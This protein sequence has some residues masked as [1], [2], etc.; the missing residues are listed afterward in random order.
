MLVVPGTVA[1][2]V[3]VAVP[4]ALQI[5]T[6]SPKF[7]VA[8]EKLTNWMNKHPKMAKSRMLNFMLPF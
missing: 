8:C 3:I 5:I 4:F 1:F 6:L 2:A 7:K